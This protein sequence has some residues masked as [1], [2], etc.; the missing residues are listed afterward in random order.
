MEK[1]LEVCVPQLVRPGRIEPSS[2][3]KV[4]CVRAAIPLQLLAQDM[5][6]QLAGIFPRQP[7]LRSEAARLL[8]HLEEHGLTEQAKIPELLNLR[9]YAVTRLLSKLEDHGHV[10]RKKEGVENIVTLVAQQAPSYVPSNQEIEL[11]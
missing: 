6:D 1:V 3:G 4:L 10:K 8:L 11:Q 9:D 2:L 7:E 5:D